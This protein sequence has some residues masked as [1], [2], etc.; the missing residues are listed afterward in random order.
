MTDST[1]TNAGSTNTLLGIARFLLFG[2]VV[3]VFPSDLDAIIDLAHVSC[4]GLEISYGNQKFRPKAANLLL[5]G[6]GKKAR[7]SWETNRS[8]P[9]QFDWVVVKLVPLSLGPAETP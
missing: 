3:P 9:G 6:K 7:N 5:P 4:G 2:T 8:E 1:I